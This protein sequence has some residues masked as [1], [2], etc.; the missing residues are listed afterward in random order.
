MGFQADDPTDPAEVGK[1]VKRFF[2]EGANANSFSNMKSRCAPTF[3]VNEDVMS[4]LK[5][6]TRS[7]LCNAGG[8]EENLSK[9][10]R[11]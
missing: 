3:L 10:R 5:H 8:H 6:P 7:P 4:W 1:A 9:W 2:S 11:T